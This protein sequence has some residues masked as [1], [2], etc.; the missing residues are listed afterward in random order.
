MVRASCEM[1]PDEKQTAYLMSQS[2]LLSTQ[3]CSL[4]EIASALEKA[5]AREAMRP[6]ALVNDDEDYLDDL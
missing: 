6:D 4:F 3:L 1:S 2:P 5:D